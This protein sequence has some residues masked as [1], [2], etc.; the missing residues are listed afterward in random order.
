MKSSTRKIL[1]GIAG[2]RNTKWWVL[3]RPIVRVLRKPLRI[4]YLLGLRNQHGINSRYVFPK[5]VSVPFRS[6]TDPRSVRRKLQLGFHEEGV[7]ELEAMACAPGKP[8][9]RE[10]ALW[11]LAL[12]FT[13]LPGE[14]NAQRALTY[15]D[16]LCALQK[17]TVPHVFRSILR[18]DCLLRTGQWDAARL[19]ALNVSAAFAGDVN[20]NLMW[21]NVLA[22]VPAEQAACMQDVEAVRLEWIND[23]LAMTRLEPMSLRDPGAG[24]SLDNIV[25][26]VK[27]AAVVER[28]PLVTVIIPVYNAAGR[29]ETAVRSLQNQTW[30]NLEILVVDD[31]STDETVQVVERLMAEDARI[32]L[33]RAP[34][35]AG[36]YVARNLGLQHAEGEF[37]TTHDDDD[38]SHP[39]KIECQ[40]MHLVENPAVV[41]NLSAHVRAHDDLYFDLR[42][43]PGFYLF[44]NMSSLMFRREQVLKDVGYW[45]SVRYAGDSE[46]KKRLEA[47]YGEDRVQSLATGPLSI[48]RMR[49]ASL[50]SSPATGYRGYKVGSRRDYEEFFT[51]WHEKSMARDRRIYMPFP[52][53]RRPFAAPY[54]MR[55]S[56]A[57]ETQHFDVILV[58]D[59]RLDGGTTASNIQEIRA[60]KALGLRVGLAPSNAYLLRPNRPINPRIRS[61]VDGENVRLLSWGEAAHADL[62]LVRFPPV[63]N[64]RNECMPVVSGDHVRIIANQ[65]PQRTWHAD[66]EL[67]YDIEA[68][69]AEARRRYGV[70]PVWHPIGPTA[71]EGLLAMN[72][73]FR[74]SEKDWVNIIN[75]DE[76]RV[77]RE[78]RRRKRI[79]IGRHSRD[80]WVKWPESAD[81][82]TAIYPRDSAF[83]VRVLGGAKVPEAVLGGLPANW[84]VHSFGELDPKEFLADLDV[85][86]YFTHSQYLEA[87]GRAIFEAMAVGVPVVVP[88]QFRKLFEDAA[89]Y[90]EP[91]EVANLVRRLV[92]DPA[93]YRERV[94]RGREFV[95]ARFGYAQHRARLEP[96][97]ACLQQPVSGRKVAAGVTE[98]A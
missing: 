27:P 32:R 21:A 35:N 76:W 9:R 12:W 26:D 39:R 36:P 95:E 64:S 59:F 1:W 69:D 17:R 60:C 23:A 7:R 45:D 90:A 22:R 63:L 65:P 46:F 31:V 74:L 98:T 47:F 28:G 11:E 84:R 33:V 92:E 57:A 19:E 52:V 44:P 37:V 51:H 20:L 89:L 72:A 8:L 40:A 67:L 15:L 53:K 13:H 50:T 14:E 93:F 68:C 56:S 58:S 86:V 30:R 85:F 61:L 77:E 10:S 62:V 2:V 75:V 96:L 41:A 38:W 43:N 97:V 55:H 18:V 82:L 29:L 94:R 5:T 25:V 54:I 49:E 78:F 16:Q 79:V 4:D 66:S 42:G 70:E 48:L 24:I 91:A 71:R 88:Q 81:D 73:N 6:D 3:V 87:F 80:H 83:E 34:E